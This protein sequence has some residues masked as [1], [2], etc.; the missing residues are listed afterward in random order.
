MNFRLTTLTAAA[1]A[2]CLLSASA[3]AARRQLKILAIGNSFTVDAVQDDLEPLALADSVDITVGYPY[4][5]GTS[6]KQ[7]FEWMVADSAAYNY[8]KV[9]PA[10][11]SERRPHTT[12]K[13]AVCDEHWDWVI[14]QTNHSGASGFT[15]NYLPYLTQL[16][17]SVKAHIANPDKVR[18]GL[19][20][21]W[22]Y[23][24]DSRYKHFPL[25]GNDQN[26]MYRMIAE[27]APKALEATGMQLLIPA[28]TAI[29]N[30]RTT[31]AFGD[32]MNRDGYHMDLDHGR[33]T[34]ACTWYEAITGRPVSGNSYRPAELSA[35]QASLC[36]TAAHLAIQNPL[37]ITD[38]S[39]F[40]PDPLTAAFGDS[41]PPRLEL[42]TTI[43]PLGGLKKLTY[44][45]LRD[46]RNSGLKHIEIS[47][48]GLVNGS[49]PI[50]LPEL[51]RRFISVKAAADSAGINIRSIHMPYG[52]DCDPAALDERVRR[53]S[54]RRYRDYISLVKV[55][56]PEYILFHP[57]APRMSPGDRPGHMRQ[58]AK[59]LKALN[60]DVRRIGAN[61]IV[62]NLRGPSVMRA[63]GTERG[64]G[65]TVEEMTELMSMLPDDIYA[66][67]DLNHIEH[68]EKMIRALGGRIRSLHVCDSDQSRDCHFLPWRGTNDWAEIVAALYDTGY[69][70][71]WMYEIKAGEIEQLAEMTSAY[72]RAY[73]SY[74]ERLNNQS[75][76]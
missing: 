2:I 74:L 52:P 58:A 30:L 11:A 5:G 20:M 15:D 43:A 27:T 49:N 62:E 6:M 13:Q 10:G 71:V 70:G 65:R 61:I 31:K 3:S 35:F 47:L 19:Y 7:H 39:A 26:R 34:V 64:L 73:R 50:P 60:K 41:L 37:D 36:R 18:W 12:L 48:T 33:Y 63:D 53:Q 46:L 24:K 42:G 38:M 14:I 22:A 76:L 9:G 75:D 17:D 51:Q 4:K 54:E 69:T 32:R 59:T 56:E 21:T 72:N 1:V 23:D 29:Q 45:R 66:V 68:P 25:Y 44:S 67:V 16:V 40:G 55:L 28:G 8:R 57:S